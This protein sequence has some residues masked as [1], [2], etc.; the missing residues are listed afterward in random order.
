MNYKLAKIKVLIDDDLPED[1]LFGFDRELGHHRAQQDASQEPD[2]VIKKRSASADEQ[3]DGMSVFLT[4]AVNKETAFWKL[5]GGVSFDI[6]F[7]NTRKTIQI[8]LPA[9][10]YDFP[11]LWGLI[12]NILKMVGFYRY[13]LCFVHGVGFKKNGRNIF[14]VGNRKD[15]KTKVLLESIRQKEK[16]LNE[17]FILLDQENIYPYFPDKLDLEQHHVEQLGMKWKS[18]EYFKQLFSRTKG[19]GGLSLLRNIKQGLD[20]RTVGLKDLPVAAEVFNEPVEFK[21]GV[22]I[23]LRP[24]AGKDNPYQINK[25][26][27]SAAAPLAYWASFI[28][29]KLSNLLGYKSAI[30]GNFEWLEFLEMYKNRL[31]SIFETMRHGYLVTYPHRFDPQKLYHAVTNLFNNNDL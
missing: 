11:P 27:P 19:K 17:D 13:G 21:K 24:S 8:L 22:F 31:V 9:Q 29:F 1:L 18:A 28:E 4:Y 26:N 3:N 6:D 7:K 16:L 25:I 12:E 30:E 23:F 20:Y 2:V 5:A 14:L 15:G 10:G